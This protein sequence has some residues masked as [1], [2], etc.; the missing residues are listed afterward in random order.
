MVADYDLERRGR[1]GAGCG[2]DDY[3]AQRLAVMLMED[4]DGGLRHGKCGFAQGKYPDWPER[5]R[6]DTAETVRH[7]GAWCNCHSG[8][9]IQ[10]D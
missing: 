4:L 7:C 8:N 5:T 9:G 6:N 1:G 3:T 2:G 10:L